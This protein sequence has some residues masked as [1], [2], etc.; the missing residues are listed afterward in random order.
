[1]GGRVAGRGAGPLLSRIQVAYRS[2]PAQARALGPGLSFFGTSKVY[3]SQSAANTRQRITNARQRPTESGARRGS[4]H[5]RGGPQ[6]P[7]I[8]KPMVLQQIGSW[9]CHKVSSRA[10]QLKRFAHLAASAILPAILQISLPA[11]LPALLPSIL[12]TTLCAKLS[13]KLP[14][15]LPTKSCA[16]TS[17]T[18]SS[19]Y[20]RAE[21]T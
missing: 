12:S 14:A 20:E 18:P 21:A 19:T 13:T 6:E 2:Y 10:A 8:T 5:E 7:G 1:M 17:T 16:T 9:T 15:K 3:G 11:I 4:G